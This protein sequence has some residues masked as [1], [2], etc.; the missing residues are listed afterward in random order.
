VI[1][2]VHSN[3]EPGKVLM[4]TKECIV[5]KCGSG[6]ISLLEVEPKLKITEGAYL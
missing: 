5:V 6:A 3:I 4:H 2:D 1:D